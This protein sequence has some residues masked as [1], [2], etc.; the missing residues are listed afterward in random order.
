M[1]NDSVGLFWDDTPPPKPPKKEKLKRIPPEAVWL[2][3]DYLPG[4]EEAKRFPVKVMTFDELVHAVALKHHFVFD[5]ESYP[6]YF[7]V[8]FTDLITGW[9]FI[10]ES[11]DG[12]IGFDKN[13]MQ[14]CLK[15]M[16]LIGFNSISYDMPM[17]QAAAQGYTNAQLWDLTRE[18]IV[19]DQNGKDVLRSRKIKYLPCDH[20]DL[21]EIAPLQ[22]SLKTYAGR[23]HARKM[24][25]LPFKPGTVLSIDQITITR[26]YCVND[27]WNTALLHNAVEEQI[28]LRY[29]LSN[30]YK[31]D[32]RSKSDAQIAEAVIGHEY[33]RMTGRSADR[34]KIEVGTIYKY[35]IPHFIQ[36]QTPQLQHALDVIRQALF[37]VEEHGSVGMPQE[38]KDLDIRIGDARYQMGIGGLHSTESTQMHLTDQYNILF[39]K[40]VT[41]YYPYIIL[42]L[43]L[44]P[45]HLGQPFLM[46]Y[47]GIVERRIAA[48][49]AKRNIEAASLKIVVNGSFGKLGSKYS[50][51]Y[52]P[53]LLIQVTV[54]GQLSLIMLIERLHLA[55]I[56]VVS[57]NTDGIV[58][59]CPRHLQST[60]DA[61]VAQWEK[62][63]GFPTEET[64]YLGLFS[65]D[66]N[67]YIAIKQTF[68]EATK[69]WIEKP[70]GTKG[71]GAYANP[72]ASKKNNADKLQKNPATTICVEAVGEFLTKGTPIVTTIQACRDITKFVTVRSVTGGAVKVWDRLPPPPHET[73][74]DLM[75]MA[76]FYEITP[77]AWILPGE[78]Q[79]HAR[80]SKTA[81]K[82]AV[83]KL[84]APGNTDYIGKTVR[85]YYAKGV[86]GEIVYAKNGNKVPRSDGAM[87]IMVFDGKFPDDVDF[88][89]YVEEARSI[90]VDVGVLPPPPK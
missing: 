25:D 16:T 27:T 12:I 51:L 31:I 83:D 15:N 46:V 60:M 20:I 22:A 32:L 74:E 41:S 1:R 56:P 47:R 89:W 5:V 14:W 35:K 63:T 64:R 52:S 65:R 72:W 38:I 3:P 59:K 70:D 75:R 90:L 66:V 82:L 86:T 48:K 44:T 69:T 61:I 77:D 80:Y 17:V 45:A 50:I 6:N 58:I 79:R 37:V 53:D 62:D 30:E 55:G 67:N 34:P 18:I 28:D 57:A 42:N 24:Q 84:S 21:I 29:E 26:W 8:V 71:K 54:T 49:K 40:D 10:I 88:D 36:F 73:E 81:Y 23:L 7:L 87:P 13:M 33:K 2:Q 85:W 9:S 19:N 76:G 43:G 78:T 11:I 4:L 39:D 68:D